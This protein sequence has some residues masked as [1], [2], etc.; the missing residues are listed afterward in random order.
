MIHMKSLF[1]K[2]V[3]FDLIISRPGSCPKETH[4][5][6]SAELLGNKNNLSPHNGIL[7]NHLE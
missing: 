3:S 1:K 6:W 5:K 7:C 4:K 2:L